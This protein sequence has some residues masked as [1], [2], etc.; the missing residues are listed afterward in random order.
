MLVESPRTIRPDEIELNMSE[1]VIQTSARFFTGRY[2][3][4]VPAGERFVGSFDMNYIQHSTG[5]VRS[6]A[7]DGLFKLSYFIGSPGIS[8]LGIVLSYNI[9]FGH[10][11]YYEHG[12]ANVSL[13][14]RELFLG[15]CMRLDVQKFAMHAFGGYGARQRGSGLFT[16]DFFTK[17]RAMND[18]VRAGMGLNCSHLYPFI[19]SVEM[20]FVTPVKRGSGDLADL[21]V[22]GGRARVCDAVFGTSLF[23]SR[24]N[25]IGVYV[26]QPIIRS[27]DYL[28]R[29]IDFCA[30]VRF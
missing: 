14:R 6:D 4:S 9:P 22:E 28:V 15:P 18:V 1:S 24:E 26:R 10:D 29:S 3:V 23:L 12:L 21:P 27:R 20:Y 11:V 5:N 7:G 19:P 13:G 17:K 2:G 16:K 25:S 30:S 8:Q